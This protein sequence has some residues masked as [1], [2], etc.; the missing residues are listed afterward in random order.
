MRNAPVRSGRVS[1]A[2]CT[3]CGRVWSEGAVIAA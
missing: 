2:H 3:G 1:V